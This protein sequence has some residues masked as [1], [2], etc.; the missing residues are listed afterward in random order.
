[1]NIHCAGQEVDLPRECQEHF[2]KGERYAD[3][4]EV[5]DQGRP[6]ICNQFAHLI[7]WVLACSPSELASNVCFQ[8]ACADRGLE[9]S[10]SC[11]A[12]ENVGLPVLS[13]NEQMLS[14]CL[15]NSGTSCQ[16]CASLNLRFMPGLFLPEAQ[17]RRVFFFAVAA[18]FKLFQDH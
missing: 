12:L 8:K 2:V 16:R 9:L 3:S 15:S 7:P 10:W 13:S 17:R 18:G 1:M 11:A 14:S 4:H 5:S 6:E